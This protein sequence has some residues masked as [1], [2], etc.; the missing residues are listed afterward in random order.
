MLRLRV[1][2]RSLGASFSAGHAQAGWLYPLR[3]RAAGAFQAPFGASLQGLHA[4]QPDLG[5]VR[6]RLFLAFL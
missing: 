6:G 1:T 5:E 4:A 3:G 2:Y